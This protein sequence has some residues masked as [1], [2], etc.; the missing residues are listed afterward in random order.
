MKWVTRERPKIDRIA[1]R[2]LVRR[3]IDPFAEFVFVPEPAVRA[4]AGRPAV[5]LARRHPS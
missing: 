3:F 1:C 5:P 4:K 2:W